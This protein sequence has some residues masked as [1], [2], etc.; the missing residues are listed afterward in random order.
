MGGIKRFHTFT[1]LRCLQALELFHCSIVVI[2]IDSKLS[3]AHCIYWAYFSKLT[4]V[5]QNPSQFIHACASRCHFVPQ[6]GS[7]HATIYLKYIFCI[8]LCN[9]FHIHTYIFINW[10]YSTGPFVTSMLTFA[11]FHNYVA[12]FAFW[13]FT[14]FFCHFNLVCDLYVEKQDCSFQSLLITNPVLQ[15]ILN[16]LISNVQH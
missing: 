14:W 11:F 2:Y 10:C 12:P 15:D 6:E 7:T 9:V 13:L 8:V 4:S 3:A 16:Q 5:I 1:L